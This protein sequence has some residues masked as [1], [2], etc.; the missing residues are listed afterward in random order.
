MTLE[1]AQAE[2]ERLKPL[3]PP[4]DSEGDNPYSHDGPPAHNAFIAGWNECLLAIQRAREAAKH[5]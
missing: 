1:E 2:I 4:L 3:V 5:E